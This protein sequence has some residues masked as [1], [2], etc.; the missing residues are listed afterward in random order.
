MR[1]LKFRSWDKI[2]KQYYAVKGLEYDDDGNLDEVYL[3][4]LKISESNPV[5]NL[6]KPSD[7]I[8]E[9]STGL[10]DKNCKEIYEGDIIREKWFD[11]DVRLGENRVGKVE[12]FTDGFVCWFVGGRLMQLGMLVGS[13]IEVIGNIYENK[14]LLKE[15]NEH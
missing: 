14:E 6:R 5:F 8:L 2:T 13:H 1:D 4:G 3:A 11:E 7:V 12:Y 15:K 9:Q 10:K